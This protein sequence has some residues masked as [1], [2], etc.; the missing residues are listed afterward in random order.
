MVHDQRADEEEL[1][2]MKMKCNDL[3]ARREQLNEQES[4]HE[5]RREKVEGDIRYARTVVA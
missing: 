3:T 5:Q 1:E 4:Q 2:R